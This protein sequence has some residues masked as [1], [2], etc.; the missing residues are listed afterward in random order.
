M[1]IKQIFLNEPA[2]RVAVSKL[3]P[4]KTLT[5][6]TLAGIILIISMRIAYRFPAIYPALYA[7]DH[8]IIDVIVPATMAISS[9]LIGATVWVMWKEQEFTKLTALPLLTYVFISIVLFVY[10]GEEI[11]WGQDFLGW[12]TPEIFAGN[13][14]GQT[15]LHNYLNPYF[16]YGYIAIS[17]IIVVLLFAVWL[18][19][20]QHLMPYGR[21]IM[22]HPGLIGLGLLITFVSIVWF[23]EE[24][25]LEEM[26]AVFVLFYSLRVF[27]N[28]RHPNSL[29]KSCQQEENC[30]YL[31]MCKSAWLHQELLNKQT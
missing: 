12:S 24:E 5:V 6:S 29:I 23:H 21:L 25:L 18:E 3:S 26:V 7:K 11:S 1:R 31:K 27:I 15:N 4:Q 22:P 9:L 14:E 16:D 20:K 17:L 2:C 19:Y 13:L 8:G 10:A 30:Y 28:L